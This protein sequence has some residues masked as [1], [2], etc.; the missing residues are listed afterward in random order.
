M[1][2]A[3]AGESAGVVELTMGEAVMLISLCTATLSP[4]VSSL[5][6]VPLQSIASHGH[7]KPSSSHGQV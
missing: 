5:Y 6:I 4:S 7:T 3:R 1:I 2:S